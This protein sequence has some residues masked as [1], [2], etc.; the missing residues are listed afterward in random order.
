MKVSEAMTGDV[1]C[2]AA[3]ATL[4]DAAQVMWE[5]DCGFVPVTEREGGRFVG[6]VTD[7]DLCM[8]AYT[9]GRPLHEIPVAT[10]M[11]RDVVTIK[12][13]DDVARAL[14]LLRRHQ[15]R[16]L[17]VV[18]ERGEL[19]GVLSLCD[20]ARTA[21]RKRAPESDQLKNKVGQALAEIGRPRALG[22]A[23]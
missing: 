5:R 17:P 12:A 21:S 22:A 23:G 4:N 8:A 2:C 9:Q 1:L 15:L 19:V 16:R 6:V 14:D 11:A 20:V 10:A 18:D 3:D 13:E 7:R